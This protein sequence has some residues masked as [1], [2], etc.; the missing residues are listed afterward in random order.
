ML[1]QQVK[2]ESL[3]VTQE[4]TLESLEAMLLQEQAMLQQLLNNHEV[5]KGSMPT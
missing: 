4:K 1:E 2:L 5:K 3:A